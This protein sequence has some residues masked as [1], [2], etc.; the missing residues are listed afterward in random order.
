VEHVEPSVATD[1]VDRF[2]HGQDSSLGTLQ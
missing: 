1:Q 2:K